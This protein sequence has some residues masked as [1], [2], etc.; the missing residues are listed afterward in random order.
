MVTEP[1]SIGPASQ[2]EKVTIPSASAV[3]KFIATNP[4]KKTA[5]NVDQNAQSVI[6]SASIDVRKTDGSKITDIEDADMIY[7]EISNG[8]DDFFAGD[9]RGVSALKIQKIGVASQVHYSIT[10]Y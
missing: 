8:T 2:R 4:V 9:N 6:V 1:L 5:I 7:T 3:T 10:Q